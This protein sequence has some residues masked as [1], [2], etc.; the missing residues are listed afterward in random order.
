MKK[1]ESTSGFPDRRSALPGAGGLSRIVAAGRNSMRGLME[2]LRSEAAIKQE[3]ALLVIGV[4]LAMFVAANVWV[5]LA[6]VGSLLFI[7]MIEF[8][9]TAIEQ[10]CNHV[11]PQRHEAIRVTK[12]LASAAVFFALLLAGLVWGAALLQRFGVFG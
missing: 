3:I 11:T 8:L 10:L 9:N 6:M 4:P 5:W 7:L 1:D 12:D 2:G